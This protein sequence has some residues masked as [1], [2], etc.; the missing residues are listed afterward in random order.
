[1]SA[2]VANDQTIDYVLTAY[3]I[4]GRDTARRPDAVLD[5]MGRAIKHQNATSVNHRYGEDVPYAGYE[6]N[7]C[8]RLHRA[9][10]DY[11]QALKF[12][13]CIEYNSCEHEYYYA[14]NA[15]RFIQEMR[16]EFIRNLPGYNDAQW[17]HR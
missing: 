1:M 12:L 6:Y 9:N 13:D 7:K 17:E 2:F 10:V 4:A 5:D 3:Q 8:P 15:Y 16:K 14:T 11:V